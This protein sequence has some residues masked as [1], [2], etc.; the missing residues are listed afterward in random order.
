MLVSL[1]MNLSHAETQR[2]VLKEGFPLLRDANANRR[3]LFK[4]EARRVGVC[5]FSTLTLCDS[6]PLRDTNSY[7]Y[8][9]TPEIL[10][11]QMNNLANLTQLCYKLIFQQCV[12]CQ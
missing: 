11:E 9:K 6:A 12:I 4:T 7:F 5:V 10:S 3:K 2:K 8:S 1:G